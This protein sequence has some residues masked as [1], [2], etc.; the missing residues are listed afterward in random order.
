[1]TGA[2]SRNV[3]KS[4]SELKVL[5]DNLLFIHG[6]FADISQIISR[7]DH[8]EEILHLPHHHGHHNACDWTHKVRRVSECLCT[9]ALLT[10]SSLWFSTSV[11]FYSSLAPSLLPSLLHSLS[12]PHLFSLSPLSLPLWHSLLSP[13]H[14][15]LTWLFRWPPHVLHE[16][17]WQVEKIESSGIWE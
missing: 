10:H 3:S 17:R 11:L 8:H 6:G 9:C 2:F 5:T 13:H 14:P 1:M 12:F 15:S 7:A 4:F 16:I